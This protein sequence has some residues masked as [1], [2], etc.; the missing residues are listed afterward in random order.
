[1]LKKQPVTALQG[2][3]EVLTHLAGRIV[4]EEEIF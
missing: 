3:Q 1:V 2:G 4:E